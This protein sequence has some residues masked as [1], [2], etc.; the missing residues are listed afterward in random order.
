MSVAHGI[1]I[2]VTFVWLGL[3]LGIS[4]LEAPIKFRAPGITVELGVGIGRLVFRALNTVEAVAAIVLLVSVLVQ[5]PTASA[6]S[7]GLAI[8]LL[9]ML[10]IG[11][12]VL[13]PLMDQRVRAGDTAERMPRH[14]LHFGYIGLEVLKVVL[15]VW[16]GVLGLVSV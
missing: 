14:N 9:I 6:W 4:F 15:L 10:A 2:A 7:L 3:V 13:R 11:A 12:L 8:A 5:G 16:I 1:Q